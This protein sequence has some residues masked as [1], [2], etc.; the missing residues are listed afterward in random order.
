MRMATMKNEA[1]TQQEEL[2]KL[3]AAVVRFHENKMIAEQ[4]LEREQQ[5]LLKAMLFDAMVSRPWHMNRITT[6][7]EGTMYYVGNWHK[8]HAYPMAGT[9]EAAILIAIN[10][11]KTNG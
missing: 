9:P 5:I 11:E 6:K 1:M 3:A 2:A 10:L 7:E 8:S 4:E